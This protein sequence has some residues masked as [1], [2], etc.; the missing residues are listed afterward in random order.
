MDRAVWVFGYGSL[1]WDPGFVPAEAVKGRL[2]GYSRSFCLRSIT[3]R[4]TEDA[5]GLVLGLD[6]DAGAECCG[7]ALRIPDDD[8]DAV[9]RY[10]R[11]RELDTGAYREEV[12]PVTLDDGRTVDAIAYVMQRDSWQ[13]AGGLCVREQARIIAGAQGRRGPNYEY[14]FNTA[15]HLTEIGLSDNLMNSLSDDVRRLLG[16][17]D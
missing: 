10:L 14:L 2:A 17:Q 3:Y 11:Q 4:G 15:D 9:I 12:L 13:Y 1:M 8:Y 5:P 6:E 7:L 16:K